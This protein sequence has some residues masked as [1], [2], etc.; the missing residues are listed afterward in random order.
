MGRRQIPEVFGDASKMLRS[1]LRCFV[2]VHRSTTSDTAL[3]DVYADLPVG[4]VCQSCVAAGL[5]PTEGC[6]ATLDDSR[7]EPHELIE[8]GSRASVEHIRDDRG[9]KPKCG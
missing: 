8:F 3:R 5:G 9:D 1:G 6:C 4:M 7:P 2:A